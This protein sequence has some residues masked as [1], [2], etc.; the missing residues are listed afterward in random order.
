[1]FPNQ[2]RSISSKASSETKSFTS[3]RSFARIFPVGFDFVLW[4]ARS[5]PWWCMPRASEASTALLAAGERREPG[6][7]RVVGPRLDLHVVGRVGVDQV[8]RGPAEQPVDRRRVR[9]VPAEEPVVA[10]DPEVARAG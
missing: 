7:D 1:M 9:G 6:G 10:Q 5:K 3:G 2:A 4:R 8:D